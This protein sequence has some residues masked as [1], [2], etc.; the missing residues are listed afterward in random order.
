MTTNGIHLNLPLE[1][2]NP[3]GPPQPGQP[4]FAADQRRPGAGAGDRRGDARARR[5]AAYVQPAGAS[6]AYGARGRAEAVG[7]AV[8]V[9]AELAE[10]S[11]G[12]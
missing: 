7:L 8:E 3:P 11:I 5:S 9:D 4:R 1:L 10:I 12:R 2:S 6:A